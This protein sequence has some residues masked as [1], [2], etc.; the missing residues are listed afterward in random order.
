MF[1]QKYNEVPPTPGVSSFSEPYH[2]A[3]PL[4]PLSPNQFYPE[5]EQSHMSAGENVHLT[6]NGIPFEQLV[7][8]DQVSVFALANFLAF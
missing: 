7:I 6:S 2:N 5:P 3:L 1:P 4:Y 8:E